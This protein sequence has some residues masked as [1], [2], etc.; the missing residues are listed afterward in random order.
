MDELHALNQMVEEIC[1]ELRRLKTVMP[2]KSVL[3]ASREACEDILGA[4]GASDAA[5]RRGSACG[6][7]EG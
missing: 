1:A 2:A 5:A 6:L 4:S 3:K 7:C